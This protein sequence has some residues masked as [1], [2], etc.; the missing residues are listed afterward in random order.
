MCLAR[1]WMYSTSALGEVVMK[2]ELVI[3]PFLV[4]DSP[5]AVMIIKICFTIEGEIEG[6]KMSRTM[7]E[8]KMRW[9]NHVN[10][11]SPIRIKAISIRS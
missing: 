10:S 1:L 11:L 9:L 4:Y 6:G 2:S 3:I 5:L 7:K 8:Q